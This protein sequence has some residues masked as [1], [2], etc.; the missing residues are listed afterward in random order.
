MADVFAAGYP[1]PNAFS[2]E[3]GNAWIGNFEIVSAAANSGDKIYLGIIPA[4]VRVDL[5]RGSFGDTGTGNTIDVGYEPVDGST[6][7]AVLNYWWNDL[8][9]ATA[10][11]PLAWSNGAPIMFDKPVKV[12][13]LV[14][15]ANL[16][17]TPTLRLT[18]IGEMVGAK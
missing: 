1:T 3:K 15:S 11:V 5:V 7:S 12:V 10:A 14:N 6:P 4:G 8:D 17:G 16:A 13:I 2:A 18:M 9:T